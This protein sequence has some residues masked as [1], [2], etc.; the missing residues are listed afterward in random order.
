MSDELNDQNQVEPTEEQSKVAQEDAKSSGSMKKYLLFGGIG[1]VVAGLSIAVTV[2]MMGGKETTETSD[3][4]GE[5]V[6]AQTEKPS[7]HTNQPDD[8]PA[9][10]GHN[11]RQHTTSEP[12]FE[13]FTPPEIEDTDPSVL[14]DIMAN[15]EFLDQE[16]MAPPEGAEHVRGMSVED[17]VEA[18][19]WLELETARLAKKEQELTARQRELD[20]LDKKVTQKLLRLE[21]AESAKVASLA[22]LYDGMDARAVARLVANLDDR[23]V[24]SI[25]PRMKQKNA[26]QVLSLMPA[27]RAA[28]LSKMLITIAEK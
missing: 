13:E 6:S 10:T 2:M 27:Q 23:T 22:K 25:V 12:E 15:L 4:A 17:S 19:N 16:T 3:A 21:Q 11:E 28:R 7:T 18:V 24:V 20:V 14:D 9:N 1:V 26:S 8:T 5:I